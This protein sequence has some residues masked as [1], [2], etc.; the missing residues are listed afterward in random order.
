MKYLFLIIALVIFSSELLTAQELRCNISVNSSKITGS[1]REIFRSMQMDL[2]EFMNN[3]AWTN[4]TYKNNEKIECNINIQ[5]NK[6]ISGDEYEAFLTVQSKRPVYNS[7]YRTTVLNIRD[8]NFRF[9]Y[10]E[11]QSIEFAESGNKDNLTSVLAYYAYMIIGFDYDT[12]SPEGGTEYFERA[13]V[14]VNESQN[15][16]GTK[17]GWRAFESDYNRYWLV[18]NVLNKSYAPFRQLMYDYHRK[19]LDQMAESVEE[20]RA[21]IAESLK[22]IQKVFRTRT[23][24]YIT[25]QFFD[26]KSAELINIFSKSYPDEQNRVIQILT[27]CDPSNASRYEKITSGENSVIQDDVF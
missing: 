10:Q 16:T 25:Q 18:D 27:E 2:Y 13:R 3:R 22:L 11:F 12:F 26:T 20:G 7:S 21:N 8:E 23:R 17:N 24:L 14:I 4:H 1:S 9:K 5:V 15:A 19:G 6:Q